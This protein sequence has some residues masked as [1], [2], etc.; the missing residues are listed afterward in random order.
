MDEAGS[1]PFF[2]LFYG[3]GLNTAKD[4]YLLKWWWWYVWDGKIIT[5]NILLTIFCTIHRPAKGKEKQIG[6]AQEWWT[7]FL[8][9]GFFRTGT[10][11]LNLNRICFQGNLSPKPRGYLLEQLSSAPSLLIELN[12]FMGFLLCNYLAMGACGLE[13]IFLL[14]FPD[15]ACY[16]IAAQEVSVYFLI[17]RL[18]SRGLKADGAMSGMLYVTRVIQN[19]VNRLGLDSRSRFCSVKF[20]AFLYSTW[21][22]DVH[23]N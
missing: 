15:K 11:C 12:L 16:K 19:C 20:N 22:L 1:S 18:S 3:G 5:G 8:V 6:S 13:L 10:I 4:V 2:M 9:N 7:N 21:S 17:F 23:S 14:F